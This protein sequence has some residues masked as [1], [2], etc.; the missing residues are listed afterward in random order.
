[1]G[2]EG[3]DLLLCLEDRF[4]I[5][6]NDGEAL[7]VQTVGQLHALVMGKLKERRSRTCLSSAV[8]YRVRRVLSAEIGVP[9]RHVRLDTSTEFLLPEEVRPRA[10]QHLGTAL[11]L[12]LPGLHRPDWLRDFPPI[13]QR[14]LTIVLCALFV[15]VVVL[16]L[17]ALGAFAGPSPGPLAC[18]AC[19]LVFFGMFAV[20]SLYDRLSAPYAVGV[21]KECATVR[22]L[23]QA[24]LQRN[25]ARLAAEYQ[26]IN[27]DEVWQALCAIVGQAVDVDPDNLT[28]ETRLDGSRWN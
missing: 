24:I 16:P 15:G 11:E 10:W 23:V 1:M 27:E 9:R 13:V 25:Y 22:G 8:F 26:S 19:P 21:P 7:S 2:L 17:L 12:Q 28:P 3:M 20:F 14:Y 5:C 4:G 6:L 18:L